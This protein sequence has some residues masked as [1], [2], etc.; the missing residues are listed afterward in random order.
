MKKLFNTLSTYLLISLCSVTVAYSQNTDVDVLRIDAANRR[1]ARPNEYIVKFNDQSSV[2]IVNE[3][4]GVHVRKSARVNALFE[5][6]NVISSEQLLIRSA[7]TRSASASSMYLI[8]TAESNLSSLEVIEKLSGLE[9][10]EYAEPNYMVYAMSAGDGEQLEDPM[11]V[12]QWGL[13]AINMPALWNVKPLTDKRPVIAILDTGVEITHPDLAANLWTNVAEKYGLEWKDDDNNG[14]EDDVHGWDFVNN[15]PNIV[16]NNG[17]GTHCAGIAGAVS[18]NGIGIMGA[19]P[20]AL[21]MPVTVMDREGRGSIADI[22]KGVNYAC[23]NGADVIS[24]SLGGYVHSKAQEDALRVASQTAILVAAAGNDNICLYDEHKR[25]HGDRTIDHLPCYPAAY[26]CVIGVQAT[27]ESGEFASFSNFDC[28]GPTVSSY[29]EREQYNYELAAPGQNILSTYPSGRYKKLSGTSMACPLVAGALSR[30]IQLKNYNSKEDLLADLIHTSSTQVVD[31]EATYKNDDSKRTPT[32]EII[33]KDLDDSKSGDGDGNYDAGE[34][35]DLYTTVRNVWGYARNITLSLSVAE[36]E[37][38]DIIEVLDNDIVEQI[39]LSPYAYVKA[40]KPLRFR[41]SENCADDRIINLKVTAIAENSTNVGL[42]EFSISVDNGQDF[43]GYIERDSTLEKNTTYNVT[44]NV[45]IPENVTLTIPE[46]CKL[47]F[48]K[49]NIMSVRGRLNILGVADNHVVITGGQNNYVDAKHGTFKYL[50][51]NII[52][53]NYSV[54]SHSDLVLEDCLYLNGG[55]NRIEYFSIDRMDRCCY[56]NAGGEFS[57]DF[58]GSHT[59]I[60]NGSS[61]AY[62]LPINRYEG[63]SVPE[64]FN[65]FNCGSDLDNPINLV[66]T[67]S[68]GVV[69]LQPTYWGTSNENVLNRYV[70]DGLIE[71]DLSQR[72]DRPSAEAHGLVWKILV[73]DKDAQD[74]Y[75]EMLPLGIG[76]HKFDIYFNRPMDK[77]FPPEVYMGVKLPYTQVAITEDGCWNE[78]GTIYT[79]YLTLDGKELIEGINRIYVYGAQ[80]LEHFPIPIER[81]RFN[82][83]VNLAGAL[84]TGLIAKPGFGKIEL[85]WKTIESDYPDMQGYNIYRYTIKEETYEEWG[86]DENGQ[87]GWLDKTRLVNDTII[88]NDKML[89]IGETTFTDYDV[90]PGK[91]YFYFVREMYTDLSQLAI[92]NL[93]VATLKTSVSGDSNGSGSVDVA[94]IVTDVAYLTNENPKPFI[95]EAADVN[96]DEQIDIVDIVKTINIIYQGASVSAKANQASN[97]YAVVELNDNCLT[98][99]CTVDIAGIEIVT[100]TSS[101]FTQLIPLQGF[102]QVR[103]ELPNGNGLYMAYSMNNTTLSGGK[104]KLLPL[105]ENAD[106]KE[107]ILVD[108]QGNKI[109]VLFSDI[110]SIQDKELD[111]SMP[112][113]VTVADIHGRILFTYPSTVGS[114]E[115]ESVLNTLSQGIYLLKM[116]NNGKLVKTSKVFIYQ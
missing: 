51:T 20:D 30:L 32:L 86:V 59:N 81:S 22:I 110:T 67:G 107:V 3:S 113:D 35:I 48:K 6:I 108:K 82:V 4:R 99:D 42:L 21:I 65:I 100:N 11:F 52:V 33:A 74:E 41:I 56:Y 96:K 109:P 17:H 19:N 14:F 25:K 72:L 103:S 9:E 84:E 94:D 55:G 83:N 102:E 37:D 34:I 57:L 68:L 111:I 91:V 5:S 26:S 24:M 115:K 31:V 92:S 101:A 76:K 80:D 27:N 53:G 18:Y 64:N 29:T 13:N 10:V 50:E 1:L 40:T 77:Q 58:K 2:Q 54:G 90:I 61:V 60:V 85:E 78:D 38:P 46:G 73:N 116:N 70:K 89:D 112:V 23:A 87:Y 71:V 12:D 69:H 45:V 114:A 104:N 28:D 63:T 97:A 105:S 43:H 93:V 16:D 79:V 49:N 66:T 44:G 15:S 95:F 39:S 47:K 7:A 75:D 62:G 98:V 88:I 36:N 106:V 8:K